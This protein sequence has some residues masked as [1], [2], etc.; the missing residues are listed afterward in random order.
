MADKIFRIV[1][2]D[3]ND[4]GKDD[5]T[6]SQGGV[7]IITFYDWKSVLMSWISTTSALFVAGVAII[8]FW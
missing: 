6:I 1:E 4:D 8:Q 7:P 3:I 5:I 2:E